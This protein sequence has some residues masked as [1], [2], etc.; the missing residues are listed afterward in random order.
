MERRSLRQRKRFLVSI[1]ASALLLVIG[2]AWLER[3]SLMT[4]YCIHMLISVK[5]SN[6]QVWAQRVAKLDLGAMRKLIDSLRRSDTAICAGAQAG[7][8]KMVQRWEPNDFR[9]TRLAACL[10][11]RFA[12]LSEPGRRAALE[13]LLDLFQ[14]Q[15]TGQP[16]A[17]LLVP[18][19]QMLAGASQA[20]GIGAHEAALRLAASVSAAFSSH[21][22]LLR[23]CRELTQA[24]LNDKAAANRVQAIWL[25]RRQEI[26][27]LE[28]VTP[29]LNDAIPEVRREAML[30]VGPAA[31]AV[32]TDDLL[33][34][35]HDSD[36]EVRRLCEAAL[37]SRGLRE[38]HVQL[39]RFLTDNRPEVRLQV[40]DLLHRQS[41]LDPG[42]W[43]R[44]LSHDPAPA[45]RAAAV[46][47]AAEQ[48]V[49]SLEDRLQQMAQS[50][51]SPSVRQV[52]Q[53][54]LAR[55]TTKT[56]P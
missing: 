51:P 20:T 2:L 27:L 24:C 3:T 56:T 15:Q 49:R 46:R 22:D 19:A 25:A 6:R 21:P 13:I 32:N 54:Y 33:R 55:R 7:L 30:A 44:R 39:G 5:E 43:L 12:S 9:R 16:T 45:V 11:E 28:A 34:W 52:A 41:D 17:D 37:R 48:R 35:L 40:L 42:I 36:E 29:L 31:A 38:E 10:A 1:A 18:A 4:W 53:Y 26:D 14:T 50:D 23:A 8:Q 47:A